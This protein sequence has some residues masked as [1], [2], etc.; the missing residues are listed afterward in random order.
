MI[1]FSGKARIWIAMGQTD[2]RRGMDALAR[3]VQHALG[4]DPHVGDLYSSGG[5]GAT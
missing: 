2:I 4:C 1:P 5:G 3:Q